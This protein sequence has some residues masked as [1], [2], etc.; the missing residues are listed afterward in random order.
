MVVGAGTQR[1]LTRAQPAG[2]IN[3]EERIGQQSV[4]E[5]PVVRGIGRLEHV[6]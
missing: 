1:K 4:K 3:N 6:W 5:T 2:A